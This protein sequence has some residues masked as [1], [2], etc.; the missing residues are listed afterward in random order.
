MRI[1]QGALAVNQTTNG[2]RRIVSAFG[3]QTEYRWVFR[4]LVCLV[5]GFAASTAMGRPEKF[6]FAGCAIAASALWPAY[7]WSS[8]KAPGLPLFPLFSSTF[9]LT[10]AAQFLSAYQGFEEYSDGAIL[11][12]TLTVCSFLW[13][14]TITWLF[15][16]RQPPR[17][18]KM[19]LT[20]EGRL[21]DSWLV[22]VIGVTSI[23]TSLI[24]AGW[25]TLP[26]GLRTF[27]TQG[28]LGLNIFS[29][30]VLGFR[31]GRGELHQSTR[32]LYYF[33]TVLYCLINVSSLFLIGMIMAVLM[34]F[35]GFT[36]GRREIPWLPLTSFL[37]ILSIL[38]IGKG[39]MR[40]RYWSEGEQGHFIRPWEYVSLLANWLEVSWETATRRESSAVQGQSIL[41]RTSTVY[42]LLRTQDVTPAVLPHLLGSTYAVI[43]SSIVPR[44]LNPN[45]TSPHESTTILNVYYG[46]QTF[47]AA[48]STTIG[49]GTLNE[50]YA[51]FGLV[52][53]L[54]LAVIYG[55]FFG[56]ITRWGIGLP[57]LSLPSLVGMF[58]MSFAIQTEMTASVFVASYFQGLIAVLAFASIFMRRIRFG[59]PLL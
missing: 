13:A 26:V 7:M 36:L 52:G 30:F 3:N 41:E 42:I 1:R 9:L 2:V 27:I 8:G 31:A 33:T 20:L 12:A 51:N 57:T 38:H 4:L 48:Q 46:N 55:S 50:A 37:V 25:F 15:W 35:V 32:R 21:K 5:I 17:H 23:V 44:F 6:T 45:K 18:R 43:P 58:T 47:E 19:I 39:E 53:C 54:G 14:G 59:S 49:W 29:I 34:G 28:L 40:A 22:W 11:L 24:Y 56:L 16:V 10:H